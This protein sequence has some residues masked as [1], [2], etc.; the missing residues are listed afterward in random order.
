MMNIM[1]DIRVERKVGEI[2]EIGTH[3]HS[4]SGHPVDDIGLVEDAVGTSAD[5]GRDRRHVGWRACRQGLAGAGGRWQPGEAYIFG[6]VHV[7]NLCQPGA[8]FSRTHGKMALC[9]TLSQHEWHEDASLVIGH[10]DDVVDY[11]H[12][13]M[14]TALVHRHLDLGHLD[15]TSGALTCEI[16]LKFGP[17]LG[18]QQPRCWFR[19]TRV[20]DD[21]VFSV[22]PGVDTD[23]CKI[24]AAPEVIVK[25]VVVFCILLRPRGVELLIGHYKSSW[26]VW[27][28]DS[29]LLATDFNLIKKMP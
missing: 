23:D 18:S 26:V 21:P 3:R 24:S 22:G 27:K 14:A 12:H 28:G 15:V 11:P 9:P 6:H 2:E 5:D 7:G 13:H 29:D 4:L 16:R 8:Q 10:V 25:V 20:E 19:G 17:F 1:V